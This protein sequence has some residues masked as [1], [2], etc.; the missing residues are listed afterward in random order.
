[1]D[2]L[3]K[4]VIVFG[5]N[6]FIGSNLISYLVGK[7]YSVTAFV[8]D[9]E[10][11]KN[12]W[13]L[14]NIDFFEYKNS[15][16]SINKN[17]TQGDIVV[18]LVGVLQSKSGDPW[19]PE[20]DEAHVKLVQNI[21]EAMVQKKCKKIIHISALGCYEKAPSMYLRSKAEGEKILINSGLDY[22]ILKPSVVYGPG[23]KFLNLFAKFHR[24]LPVIP[25]ATHD[26]LFQPI[27][28]EDLVRI[29]YS[30][31]I[32]EKEIKMTYECVGPKIFSLYDLVKITGEEC[33]SSKP[34]LPL[35]NWIAR[36]QA[37]VME[38]LP[39]PTILSRD[40]LDSASVPN[41]ASE[42]NEVYPLTNPTD[43]RTV[44]SNYIK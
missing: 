40:N 30:S 41:V 6:G 38:K 33:G 4:K 2:N 14:P 3:R 43:I 42:K 39:G 31:I 7:N 37:T 1:M 10:R 8:R 36:I 18:N 35:P 32:N 17:L 24:F 11:A 16:N 28:V 25:L 22:T 5:G 21:I 20:F 26:S 9:R 34:I 23:D 44:I 15:I 29:I 12:L 19:G 13:L 27:Y